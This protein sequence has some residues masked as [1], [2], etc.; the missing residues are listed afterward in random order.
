MRRSSPQTV[1]TNKKKR[2]NRRPALINII[3]YKLHTV[4][5]ASLPILLFSVLLKSL[6][7]FTPL[8]SAV[9]I[10]K[11]VNNHH[12]PRAVPSTALDATPPDLD[13]IGLVAGQENYGLAV[14]VLGEGLYSFFQAPSLTN[15]RVLIPP[16]V[17]AAVLVTVSGPLITSGDF[18]SV[19]TGLWIAT[20]VSTLM[21]ASYVLRLTSP[22]SLVPKEVAALGLLV[23]VAGFFSFG[24][25]LLVDGFVTLP[26]ITLP[27][28]PMPPSDIGLD[29][30]VYFG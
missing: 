14:V 24:Q 20:A 9:V 26:S 30:G 22:F 4:M 16:I 25:N 29:R 17:A 6:Y 13:V 15:I 23:A 11:N 19:G 27:G 2:N 5:R 3:Q 21:G 1:E 12:H 18:S 28:L 10:H 8:H 7:G